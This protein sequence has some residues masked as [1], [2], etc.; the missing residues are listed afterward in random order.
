M[1]TSLRRLFIL[2]LISGI[3]MPGCKKDL[4][5]TTKIKS[6]GSCER[7]VVVKEVKN[8]SDLPKIAFPL[9]A[10]TSWNI[11]FEKLDKDT[12][13]SYVAR[14][15]FNDVNQLNN[16]YK[17]Q[18]KIRLEITFEKKFRWF[19]TYFN[20][21]ET[22]KW[23]F[24]FKR[25]PLASFL[26]KEEYANNKNGDTSTAL[27]KR[28]EEFKDENYYEEFYSR[29]IDS[30]Q[31]L[32]DPS[33]PVS[34]FMQK[35]QAL[36]KILDSPSDKVITKSLETILEIKASNALKRCLHVIQ[37]SL[38]DTMMN[39]DAAGNYTNEVSMPG[40]ILNTNARIVEGNTVT[41]KFDEDKTFT[42]E[43]YTMV[44]ESRI[45]NTWA[46][47]ATGGG[48]IIIIALLTLPRL[49]RQHR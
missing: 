41:W 37:K 13:C 34:I 25:I 15:T 38:F 11:R 45:A 47:Y 42:L 28:L 23:F 21:R 16:E 18:G 36:R 27:R 8:L 19:F 35:K 32:H 48:V 31:N 22:Y 39:D 9:P 10:D 2:F 46:T 33:L 14:K 29:L 40:I 7:I 49:R 43:D 5:T 12:Q 26:T 6:D 17:E 30:V 20:Y 3:V 44:V 24:P 4:K 1:K